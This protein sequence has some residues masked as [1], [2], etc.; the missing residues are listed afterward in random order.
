MQGLPLKVFGNW[1]AKFKTEPQPAARK[2]LHRRGGASHSLGHTPSH[3]LSHA[4]YPSFVLSPGPIVLP[5][6][7]GHRR[8]FSETDRRHI[9]AEAA[10]PGASLSEVARRYGIARRVLPWNWKPLTVAE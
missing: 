6:R 9:L 5:T 3:T 4:T 1:R 7:A 10:K 8:R 2:L